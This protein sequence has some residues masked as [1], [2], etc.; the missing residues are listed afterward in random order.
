MPSPMPKPTFLLAVATTL[1]V[2]GGCATPS[3]LRA[4]APPSS[5]KKQQV[6]A[7]LK[8]LETGDPA[9]ASVINPSKYIQHNL[10]VPDGLAGFAALAKTLT[11]GSTRANPVRV[12]ED[13]DFVFA[14]TQ[15]EF[16]G[17]KVGFDIF[18]FE[19][20]KIVEHW[21][22]LQERPSTPNPSGHTLIDGPT[23][24]TNVEK[25]EQNKAQVRD[26]LTAVLVNGQVD[27]LASFIDG[28]HY[29]QH[30]PNIADGLSGLG[31]GL[32]AMAEKGVTMKYER[33]HKVLGE[34]NFVL[35]VS[36]GKFAGQPTSF[37]DLFRLE[38]GKLVEHWDT[39]ETIPPRESWKN[40]NGKF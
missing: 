15:Y 40:L 19:D 27:K 38:N 34:G 12:F 2:L 13:G 11:P 5:A 36:E 21:D 25:T 20:G 28:E 6:S 32:K 7:L 10:A 23:S 4:E 16:F 14:H 30:N 29:T 22:N 9:P 37:Y 35:A 31:S 8:S 3:A 39:L 1:A 26:F 33:I 18:R 17:P 24:V